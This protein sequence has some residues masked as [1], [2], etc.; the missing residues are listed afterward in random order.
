MPKELG[1]TP[2][3]LI[4][5]ASGARSALSGTMMFPTWQPAMLKVLVVAVIITSRSMISGAASAIT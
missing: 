5:A 3:A 2:P 4:A 1:E